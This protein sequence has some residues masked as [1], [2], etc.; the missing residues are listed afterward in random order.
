MDRGPG[1]FRAEVHEASPTRILFATVI[2]LLILLFVIQRDP[3][4]STGVSVN[5]FIAGNRVSWE[6]RGAL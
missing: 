2:P 5:L 4:C 3:R 6:R 1:I